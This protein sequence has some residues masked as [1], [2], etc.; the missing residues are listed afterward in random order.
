[1]QALLAIY[2]G[3]DVRRR[4]GHRSGRQFGGEKDPVAEAQF[5]DE[6]AKDLLALAV[7][8]G[9]IDDRAAQLDHALHDLAQ[10]I[11]LRLSKGVGTD[12]DHGQALPG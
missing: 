6:L 2:P 3:V 8:R 4:H 12:P 5:G 7:H 10:F 9:C 11:A 1:M